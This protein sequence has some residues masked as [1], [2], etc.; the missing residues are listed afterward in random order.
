M[1]NSMTPEAFWAHPRTRSEVEILQE[2]L[3]G[4]AAELGAEN[5]AARLPRLTQLAHDLTGRLVT[6][7][8]RLEDPPL[9]AHLEL[10]EPARPG[11]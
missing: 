11:G 7:E 10:D 6:L 1:P 8:L 4:I 2:M 5:A 9:E 3:R